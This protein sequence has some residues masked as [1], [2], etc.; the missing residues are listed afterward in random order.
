[1]RER[2]GDAAVNTHTGHAG[3][4]YAVGDVHG[5]V[6]LLR[7]LLAE[8]DP[9]PHDRMVFLGDYLDRGEDS[10]AT[11][12][13]L[14]ALSRVVPCIFL[15]GNHDDAWLQMWN[16]NG[17]HFVKAPPMEG[18][19][20]VWAAWEE[21]GGVP[22]AVGHFLARTVTAYEDTYAYYVHAAAE[23]GMPFWQTHD[24][25]RLW[26]LSEFLRSPYSWGKPVIFGHEEFDEP[27]IT[28]T[29]IGLDTAAYRSGVLTGLR[30]EDRALVQV[31]R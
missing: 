20:D 15:R 12:L 24:L 9:G 13:A 23:P 31:R 7:R 3:H 4:T 21:R 25:M 2:I 10:V 30:V 29:R 6:T 18:A 26:G 11:V 1:M 27:L 22:A 28:P 17:E 8:I 16:L 14:V 19:S 5:E